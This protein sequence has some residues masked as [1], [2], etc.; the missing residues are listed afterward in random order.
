MKVAEVE[1]LQDRPAQAESSYRA[2]AEAPG[3][4]G[5]TAQWALLWLGDLCLEQN[6]RARAIATWKG[7]TEATSRPGQIMALLVAGDGQVPATDDRFYAN[8]VEYFNGRIALL[9]GDQKRYREALRTVVRI[10]PAYDWPTPLAKHLL[11]LLPPEPPPADLPT[12]QPPTT[13]VQTP[14]P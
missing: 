13:P 3:I 6:D 4:G 9:A 2:V 8:D 11:S 5:E 10:G 14:A 12:G 1:R 7:S